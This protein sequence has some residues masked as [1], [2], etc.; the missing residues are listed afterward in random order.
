M[1]GVSLRFT[2]ILLGKM[3][4][5]EHLAHLAANPLFRTQCTQ[6]GLVL[7]I[8]VAGPLKD[9]GNTTFEDVLAD[10]TTR[11]TELDLAST[12]LA[13]SAA[14]QI[15]YANIAE[16]HILASPLVIHL[17]QADTGTHG[18][19]IL[20]VAQEGPRDARVCLPH[21]ARWRILCVVEAVAMQIENIFGLAL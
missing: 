18:E 7:S 8:S 15:A 17:A 10:C 2:A 11:A 5:A 21:Y 19:L 9:A 6:K 16:S 4:P 13:E 14:M 1:S 20:D 12:G 3:L